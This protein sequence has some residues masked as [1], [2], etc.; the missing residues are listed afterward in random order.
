MAL[1]LAMP[2]GMASMTQAKEAKKP[3]LLSTLYMGGPVELGEAP[4]GAI[5]NKRI[6]EGIDE[7]SWMEPTIED[8]AAQPRE[9]DIVL[10]L[11]PEAWA[12]VYLSAATVDELIKSGDITV[13]AGDA[14]EAA[15]I[16]NVF[17]RYDP[18]KAVVIPATH[19][20]QDHM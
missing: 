18:E 20:A 6:L 13:K 9:A 14:A 4:N 19:M 8:P 3:A 7:V 17:D 12:K 11:S 2:I 16:L 15:R 10:E 5:T 1:I